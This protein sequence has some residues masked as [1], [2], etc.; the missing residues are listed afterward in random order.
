MRLKVCTT[1]G[2]CVFCSAASAEELA[3]M[4]QRAEKEGN[5]YFCCGKVCA[6]LDQVTTISPAREAEDDEGPRQEE[7]EPLIFIGD[8]GDD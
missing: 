8:L 7:A 3:R 2:H 1:S 5:T 4:F 6:R